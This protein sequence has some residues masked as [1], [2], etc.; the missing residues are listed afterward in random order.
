[1]NYPVVT[2][3]RRP[4]RTAA[5]AS[6]A[7][8]AAALAGC[9]AGIPEST[10]SI[11][12]DDYRQRHPIVLQEAETTLDIPVGRGTAGLDRNSRD[13]VMA[14][15]AE[16]R[17]R[18]TGP[19][20]ILVPSGSGNEAAA[21]YLAGSIRKAAADTGLSAGNIVT[22]PY[23]VANPAVA[24]PI[25]LSFA[26]IKAGV[27]HECGQ[28]TE[29]VYRG[30]DNGSDAEFGCSSQSNLAAMVADPN[31]LIAPRASTPVSVDRR[32]VVLGKWIQG[33]KT[34]TDYGDSASGTASDVGN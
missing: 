22:Q 31:D 26:K 5:L 28:W 10:G 20:V 17:D 19:L 6:A 25:R 23:R 21:S 9:S 2:R 7:V 34:S 32:A 27:P 15:A 12:A 11:R 29:N 24:A 1:M 8:L 16:A 30:D 33:E 4:I 18:G 13:R 14:F 3:A